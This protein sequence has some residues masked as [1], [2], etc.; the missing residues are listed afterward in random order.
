MKAL[1]SNPPFNLKWESPPFAQI[2]PRFADFSVPPESN[3]NFAFILS[4][5]QKRK[6][7]F[8]FF[9]SQ[10]CNQKIKKKKKYGNS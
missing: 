5:L 3:A 2:Q 6:D 8:L 1:I 10:F 9:H 4:G 7:V